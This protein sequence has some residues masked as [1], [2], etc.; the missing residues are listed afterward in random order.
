MEAYGSVQERHVDVADT[1]FPFELDGVRF[2]GI[3]EQRPP[4]LATNQP[5]FARA[6][7]GCVGGKRG[8]GPVN[9]DGRQA[10]IS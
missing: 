10:D 2:T 3:R 9:G 6:K 7:G 4:L 5:G 8:L 1:R